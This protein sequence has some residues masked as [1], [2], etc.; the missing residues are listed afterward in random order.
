MTLKLNLSEDVIEIAK[1]RLK[2][3]QANYADGTCQYEPVISYH[4]NWNE[5]DAAKSRSEVWLQDAGWLAGLPT[6]DLAVANYKPG[7]DDYCGYNAD[8]ERQQGIAVFCAEIPVWRTPIPDEIQS[9]NTIYNLNSVEEVNSFGVF[10]LHYLCVE[11]QSKIVLK[12]YFQRKLAWLLPDMT[13]ITAFPLEQCFDITKRIPKSDADKTEAQ[14]WLY[15]LKDG[16]DPDS[17]GAKYKYG[18]MRKAVKQHNEKFPPPETTPY[19]SKASKMRQKKRE[20]AKR[21]KE[22]QK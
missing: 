5:T 21:E 14:M 20:K 4:V 3:E 19:R 1:I 2:I 8:A 22:Q 9:D 18:K 10:D 11:Q 13:D 12:G 16:I 17:P 7:S 6:Q 15:A